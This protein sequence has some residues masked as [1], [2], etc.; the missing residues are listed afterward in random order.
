MDLWEHTA[1]WLPGI[2][3]MAGLAVVSGPCSGA[4]TALFYLSRDEVRA[5]RIGRPRQRL[6]AQLLRDPDRLLTAV[7]FWNL[8]VNMTYFAVSVIVARR[9]ILV[10]SSTAAGLVGLIG[11]GAIIVV[12]EVIPK[13]LAVLYRRGGGGL[14]GAAGVRLV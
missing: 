4:E 7:L 14:G 5:M 12:G 11:L 2:A 13:S 3:V 8:L 10:G 6:V 1:V 9:L